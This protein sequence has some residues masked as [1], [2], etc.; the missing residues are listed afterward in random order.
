MGLGENGRGGKDLTSFELQLKYTIKM[1]Y[2]FSLEFASI[3]LVVAVGG[4]LTLP[5][6]DRPCGLSQGRSE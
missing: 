6:A 3:A 5:W 1:Q 2:R 4:P